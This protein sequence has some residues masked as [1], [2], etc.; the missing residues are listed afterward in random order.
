MNDYEVLLLKKACE[1]MAL[2]NIILSSRLDD[3][4][5]RFEHVRQMAFGACFEVAKM[6]VNP[7]SEPA[8]VPSP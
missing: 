6:T 3:L 5:S 1:E 7:E 4:E 2:K 8:S